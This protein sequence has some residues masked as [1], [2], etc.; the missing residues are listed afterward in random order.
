M[1]QLF[2]IFPMSSLNFKAK[3]HL[4]QEGNSS[5]DTMCWAHLD[6]HQDKMGFK[7]RLIEDLTIFFGNVVS[8]VPSIV[9]IPVS[10]CMFESN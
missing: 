7:P 10:N 1:R 4:L 8:I 2:C 6:I 9:K 3:L 5:R